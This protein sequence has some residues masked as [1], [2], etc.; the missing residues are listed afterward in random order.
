M[1]LEN[2]LQILKCPAKS[3][4]KGPSSSAAS[5]VQVSVIDGHEIG[6]QISINYLTQLTKLSTAEPAYSYIVYSR[7]LAIVELNLIP[8][9]FIFLLFYPCYNRLLL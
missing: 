2:M 9:A 8:P 3:S 7:F 5:S 6:G 4:H 1:I